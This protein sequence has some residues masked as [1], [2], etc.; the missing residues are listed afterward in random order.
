MK[1]KKYHIIIVMCLGFLLLTPGCIEPYDPEIERYEDIMV[2]DGLYTNA[3]EPMYVRISRSSSYYAQIEDMV[4]GA[5]VAIADDAGNVELYTEI[6]SGFYKLGKG[7]MK[8]EVGKSYKLVIET[9]DGNRYETDF[10]EI[11]KPIEIDSVYYESKAD[12]SAPSLYNAS[13][14]TFYIDSEDEEGTTQYYSWDWTETWQ[15]ETPHYKPGYED[16]KICW[17]NFHSNSIVISNTGNLREDYNY[18]KELYTIDGT[19]SRLHVNYSSL[20][21]QYSISGKTYEF[22]KKLQELSEQSGS[23]FDSPPNPVV[24]NIENVDDPYE[25]VLGYFQVS[26]VSEKRIFVSN[27][28]LPTEFFTSN[29]YDHCDYLRVTGEGYAEIGAGWLLLYR[30]EWLDTTWTDLTSHDDCYDCTVY[31][32][33]NKPAFWIDDDK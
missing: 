14:V 21:R 17:R 24:G 9:M 2:V 10:E 5:F 7:K 31:G 26:G 12:I 18:K 8:G 1:I 32:S 33:N 28:E 13:K 27:K 20:I 29:G 19:S 22:L 4:S 6:S 30:F 11:K 15:Y 25:P 16:R 23:L 3:D